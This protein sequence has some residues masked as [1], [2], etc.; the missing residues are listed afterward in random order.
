MAI[1]ES[2]LRWG[3]EVDGLDFGNFQFFFVASALSLVR[4]AALS[5]KNAI[6]HAFSHFRVVF[7]FI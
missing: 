7:C 3:K 5:N 1:P 2:V 4:P 6:T